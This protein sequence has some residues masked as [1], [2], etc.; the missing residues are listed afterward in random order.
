M[1]QFEKI[2]KGISYGKIKKIFNTKLYWNI[3]NIKDDTISYSLNFFSPN[4]V[5]GAGY[6]CD[7]IFIDLSNSNIKQMTI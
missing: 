7:L 6:S 1:L 2:K 4:K 3:I 5:I